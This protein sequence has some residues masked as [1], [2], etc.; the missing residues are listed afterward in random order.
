MS[1]LMAF[2]VNWIILSLIS[3]NSVWWVIR[4]GYLELD[5]IVKG[6]PI[7][8]FFIGADKLYLDL[9]YSKFEIKLNITLE[10]GTHPT[11][12]GR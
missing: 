5:T 11:G 6:G 8:F 10:R 2:P 1:K 4:T 7:E 3:W 9:T 12:G